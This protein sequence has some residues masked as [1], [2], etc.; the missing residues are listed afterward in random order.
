[1]PHLSFILPHWLYW[2]G[3]IAFPLFAGYMYRRQ[4]AHPPAMV[5][6]LPIA[7]LLWLTGGFVGLHRFY[8]RSYWG[9]AYIPVF[10]GILYA[11][12][13]ERLAL[14]GASEARRVLRGA[15]FDLEK[16]QAAVDKGT[17]GATDA[18]S[19]ARG[20]VEAA[21]TAMDAASR[22]LEGWHILALVLAIA[23]G[24]G[25]VIDAIL[26]PWAVRARRARETAEPI[27]PDLIPEAELPPADGF[28]YPALVRFIDE[29]NLQVGHFIA[30][31]SII[32]VFVYY[33]EVIARYVFNSPTNWAHQSM[34]L[35]FGMQ[36]LLAGGYALRVDAHVRVDVIYA[37][38][39][40]RAQ[41]IADVITSS[42]F[43]IF[44]GVLCWT[45][46]VFGWRAIK[47]WEVSF[48][49]WPIQ[50]WPVKSTIAVGAFLLLIQGIS[51]LIKDAYTIAGKGA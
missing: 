33:Y 21:Q 28:R 10:I 40:R 3:L 37:L 7:Y 41:A 30:Y 22:T 35:M 29:V 50:Y 5:T 45:G 49:E 24:V 27:P 11:N 2:L 14:D 8:I 48:T 17:A 16:A 1:M 26:L 34:F 25:L 13:R 9:I 19:L 43:F 12:Y 47:V 15:N 20:A 18:L 36:Y 44:S 42:A 51:K 39:P 23:I 38:L 32:A 4:S 46:A 6:S 31:W